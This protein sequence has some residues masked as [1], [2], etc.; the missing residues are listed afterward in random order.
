MVEPK[1]LIVLLTYN[2]KAYTK[3]TLRNLWDTIQTPYYLVAVDNNSED[4]TQEYLK[5]LQERNRIDKVILNPEN[6][7]PGKA[8]NI[9]WAEGLKEYPN[10]THL[11]RLD[12]D[13]H[14]EQGWDKAAW[15]YFEAMPSLGQL[16]IEHEAIENPKAEAH[17]I[18]VKGKT[19]CR[20]PGNV[21]GPNIISRKV[22]DSGLRYP[23]EKW[24]AEAKN[25]PTP[26][27]DTTFSKRI[28]MAGFL[29][30]HMTEKLA[31]TFANRDNWH[32]YPEYYKKTMRERG[33][34]RLLEE[35]LGPE[36]E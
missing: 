29:M 25:I 1:L 36:D 30:G 24:R 31:W 11:M 26:Q 17:N 18:T 10:A 2:R 7:Y 15:E 22:W 12:N 6:Y 34:D 4:G 20:F 28:E 14:L 33:Y 13:M 3:K 16:G 5:G 21:G 9:G 27:E 35:V 19:I 8:T 32:E 23:E